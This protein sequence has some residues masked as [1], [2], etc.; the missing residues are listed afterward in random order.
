MEA[1]KRNMAYGK[2]GKL[3]GVKSLTLLKQKVERNE[4]SM[5]IGTETNKAESKKGKR[6][7]DERLKIEDF[8]NGKMENGSRKTEYCIVLK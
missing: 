4:I 6:I 1:G 3:N 2:K 8:G 5:D 7:K